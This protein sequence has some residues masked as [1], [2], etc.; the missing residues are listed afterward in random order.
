MTTDTMSRR[1]FLGGCAS[2]GAFAGCRAVPGATLGGRAKMRMG[3]ISDVHVIGPGVKNFETDWFVKAL[4]YF[5]DHGA[6]GVMIAGDIAD[7]G[8]VSQLKYA[9]D[10][11][12][13]V[14]PNDT[15]PD[16]R[17]VE[18]LFVYGNH[19]VDGWFWDC[20]AEERKKPEVIADAIGY[21][22]ESRARTWEACFH[23]KYEPIWIKDV[24]GFKVL[25]AQWHAWKE[26]D[27]FLA[28]HADE[29]KGPKPF[30]YAQHPHPNNTCFGSWAWGSDAGESTAAPSQ[31]PNA[32]AFSGHSHYTPPAERSLWP[33]AFT[34]V[35]TSSLRYSSTDYSLRDNMPGNDWG[36]RKLEQTRATPR[37][38]TGDGHQGLLLEVGEREVVIHRVEFNW[39]QSLGDDWVLDFPDDGSMDYAA[40]AEKRSAPEFPAG[41]AVTATAG[42]DEKS[43]W[44][45]LAF[46]HAETVDGCRVF[47]YE[48]TA[49]LLADDADLV[50]AQKRVIAPDFHWPAA[51]GTK[52]G[53][54]RFLASELPEGGRFRFD[55]RPIECF[56]KKGQKI[57]VFL[58]SR[59]G[60]VA[61]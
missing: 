4:E 22:E 5:R 34:S 14:F 43:A 9:A 40:R 23:E 20:S 6:D 29:L 30:F 60:D 10:A 53:S 35:N 50:V 39:G 37:F 26:L 17:R 42:K 12:Y 58:P 48:V 27:A 44:T 41:A 49:T 57:S 15:A 8:R 56:G 59:G 52:P 47:E 51:H 38:D 11:W 24:K 31:W 32:V 16:G 28:A 45:D 21:S 61:K 46:P 36:F 1:F 33:G 18:K 54:C 2:L 19:D 13:R 7:R 25:G 3:V 55:V